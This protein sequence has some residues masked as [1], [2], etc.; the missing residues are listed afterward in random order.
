VVLA[1]LEQRLLLIVYKQIDLEVLSQLFLF[2][3][4]QLPFTVDS[5]LL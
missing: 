3:E 4:L 5:Q 1:V 2:E